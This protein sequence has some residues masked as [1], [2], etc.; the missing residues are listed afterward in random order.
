MTSSAEPVTAAPRS[1]VLAVGQFAPVEDWSENLRTIERLARRAVAR[2]ARVLV[3]PEYASTFTKDLGPALVAAAQDLDG[4]FVR[5]LADLADDLDV[6][7]VAGL[8]ATAEDPSRCSNALVA[9]AP[10]RG[11]VATYR[12]QHLYDAFGQRESE[13]VEPGPVGPPQT[14]VVDGV[15]LGMQTCYDV[16]FP[17]VTRS[18]VD[19]G[20]EV[21]LLPAEWVRGPLKEYHWRTL[22]TARAIENTVWVAA[23]DHPPPVG[24]GTSL[25]V[26]PTGVALVC[27]GD[28]AEAVAVAEV[29]TARLDEVRR[30]NPA[31]ALRRWRVEPR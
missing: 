14:F 9:V 31:L 15:V 28:E 17:E 12:K 27:I 22:V 21:V 11:L 18:L 16:R 26:D 7:L 30:A 6:V 4:P 20:A 29:S 24:V 23:A 3:L 13:W 10:V 5:G 8:V 1:T 19:A 2:G 25:V